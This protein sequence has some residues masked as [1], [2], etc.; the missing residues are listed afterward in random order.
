MC[1]YN[2]IAIHSRKNNNL[3]SLVLEAFIHS[4]NQQI[5]FIQLIAVFSVSLV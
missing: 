1:S 3:I 2:Y 5:I 4:R